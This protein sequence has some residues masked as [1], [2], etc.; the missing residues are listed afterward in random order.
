MRYY[1]VYSS[2][3]LNIDDYEDLDDYYDDAEYLEE[4]YMDELR[5]QNTGWGYSDNNAYYR[6]QCEILDIMDPCKHFKVDGKGKIIESSV[7]MT[8]EYSLYKRA[9]EELE[10]NNKFDLYDEFEDLDY[11]F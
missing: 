1:N 7:T 9:K 2:L 5:R 4:L 6:Q 10:R 11:F 8:Q 3:L